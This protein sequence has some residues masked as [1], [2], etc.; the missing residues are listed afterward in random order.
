MMGI[1]TSKNPMNFPDAE[2]KGG[3]KLASLL[4]E[5]TV[6]PGDTIIIEQYITGYG[7]YSGFKLVSYIS[8]KVFD[9]NK[10]FLYAGFIPP[11]EKNNNK[12]QWGNEKL[13]FTNDGV[14]VL[15]ASM[16]IDGWPRP[17]STFD[18]ESGTN[19]IVTE[20]ALLNAPF[21]YKLK[22]LKNARPGVKYMVFY[23]TFFNGS[24]WICEE[25]KVEFKINN[26]FERYN[27][28]LSILAALAL[29]VTI[30]HDG[31]APLFDAFHEVAKL[32]AS[33]KK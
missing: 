30:L 24:E 4:K 31:V 9:E 5:N 6:N 7:A 17:E 3:Y 29:F 20:M 12:L 32:I 27:T 22:T 18:M 15:P 11:S 28:T 13:R 21:V 16:R 8:N 23:L 14:T 19:K 2:K 33:L 25:S 1:N 26:T 10:S